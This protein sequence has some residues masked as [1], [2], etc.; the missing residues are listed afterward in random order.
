MWELSQISVD[1]VCS[2]EF[3]IQVCRKLPMSSQLQLSSRAPRSL[4]LLLFFALCRH[5]TFYKTLTSLSTV[6][7]KA[8]VGLLQLLKWLCRTSFFYPCRALWLAP[9]CLYSR[10]SIETDIETDTVCCMYY[11]LAVKDLLYWLRV[12]K[13]DSHLHTWGYSLYIF[14]LH[15]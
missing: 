8:H 1:L 6:F 7:I 12:Y 2:S 9:A 13:V 15:T 14:I 3:L 11:V 5:V 4:D 10:I